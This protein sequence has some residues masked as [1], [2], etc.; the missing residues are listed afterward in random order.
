[1]EIRRRIRKITRTRIRIK[2]ILLL[3]CFFSLVLSQAEFQICTIPTN[4]FMLSSHNGFSALSSKV[5]DQKYSF[6]LIVFPDNINYA[7]M[8]Y[9]KVSIAVLDYGTLVNQI[10]NQ[11]FNEFHAYELNISYSW[12]GLICFS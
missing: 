5:D 3:F 4:A 11:I 2:N 12:N 7:N 10:D 1:M 6:D 9:K 8:T